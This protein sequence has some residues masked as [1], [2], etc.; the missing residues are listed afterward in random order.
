MAL[1]RVSTR[2]VAA[3]ALVEAPTA[4]ACGPKPVRNLRVAAVTT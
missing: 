3:T 2:A 1:S 4:V